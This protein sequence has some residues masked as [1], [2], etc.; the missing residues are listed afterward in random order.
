M[1]ALSEAEQR[2]Q[3]GRFLLREGAVLEKNVH[4]KIIHLYRRAAV[5]SLYATAAFHS[6]SSVP[7]SVSGDDLCGVEAGKATVVAVKRCDPYRLSRLCCLALVQLVDCL[8]MFLDE[9]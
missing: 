8:P 7:G 6:P 9:S 3:L 1:G 5:F 2:N 4:P